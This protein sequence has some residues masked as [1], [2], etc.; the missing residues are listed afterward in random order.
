M[1]RYYSLTVGEQEVRLRL[2]M[3]G[4]RRLKERFGEEILPFLFSA[5]TDTE[6]LCAL[7]EEC[8]NW[9]GNENPVTSGEALYD[10]LVDEGWQGQE[11]FAR[12]VF[13]LAECSGLLTGEQKDKVQHTLGDI[14]RQVFEELG[15]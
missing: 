14:F 8:L 12:L 4:Q 10:A 13:E 7:L 11:Q 9:Q 2:T 1:K 5:A 3:G 6:L 15:K